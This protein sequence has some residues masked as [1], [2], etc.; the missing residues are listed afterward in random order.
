MY[1]LPMETYIQ[2]IHE[3][4]RHLTHKERLNFPN[5]KKKKEKAKYTQ[6]EKEIKKFAASK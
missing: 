1:C 6:N 5:Q 2:Y 4:I 3:H